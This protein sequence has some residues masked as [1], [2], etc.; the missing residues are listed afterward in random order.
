M[1]QQGCNYDLIFP[2]ITQV[3]ETLE[4]S[5][6][7]NKEAYKFTKLTNTFRDVYEYLNDPNFTPAE[8]LNNFTR[9]VAGYT[10]FSYLLGGFL[11][12]SGISLILTF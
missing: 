7:E 9:N 8:R 4:L 3:S 1:K 10:I 5:I 2:K 11:H 6:T 12:D